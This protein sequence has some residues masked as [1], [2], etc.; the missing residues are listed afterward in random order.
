MLT[1]KRSKNSYTVETGLSGI[2]YY[3]TLERVTDFDNNGKWIHGWH[4]RLRDNAS[5]LIARNG[6][7]HASRS[8]AE[9]EA[10]EAL[11]SLA[12]VA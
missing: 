12:A 7:C 2:S 9:K 11:S 4:V 8:H 5:G 1:V 6:G 10:R 3:A